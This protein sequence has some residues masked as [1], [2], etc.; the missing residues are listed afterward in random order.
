[1]TPLATSTPKISSGSSSAHRVEE[2]TPSYAHVASKNWK[3]RSG[4]I[5]RSPESS[6]ASLQEPPRPSPLEPQK[7][8]QVSP[9]KSSIEHELSLNSSD[10]LQSILRSKLETQTLSKK[11]LKSLQKTLPPSPPS[12]VKSL[13]KIPLRVFFKAHLGY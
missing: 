13:Q 2:S 7:A 9:T 5:T 1:M 11:G 8:A 12:L 4:Q 6:A 10:D 3:M